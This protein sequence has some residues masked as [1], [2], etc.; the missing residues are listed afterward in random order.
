MRN[1]GLVARNAILTTM[2]T[3]SFWVMTFVVPLIFIVY[4]AFTALRDTGA[5]D[6][7]AEAENQASQPVGVSTAMP[8]MG[9]VDS[10]GSLAQLPA[11]FPDSFFNRYSDLEAAKLALDAGEIDQLVYIPP[12][13]LAS[14][15]VEIYTM[16]F[17]VT[18]SAA[19]SGLTFSGPNAWVLDYLLNYN[20]VG[21][22]ALSAALKNPTPGI[23]A[24]YHAL[25]PIQPVEP[26]DYALAN[27]VGMIVPFI[28]Y[29]VLVMSG[30]YLLQSVSKEKENRTAEVIL[31]S[32]SPRQFMVGKLLGLGV[33]S[34][35]QLL[36]WLGGSSLTLRQSASFLNLA[37]L[38]FSPSFY[39]WALL[40]LLGGYLMFGSIMAA[41]GALAP[42]AREGN[43]VIWLLIV[44][45]MPTLMFTSEFATDPNGALPLV[46]SLFP[47][48]APSAMVTRLAVA[49]VPAWQLGLSLAGVGLTAWVVVTL[50]GRFFRADHLLSDTAFTWTRLLKGWR[51]SS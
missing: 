14:G 25:Q 7:P 48:S 20:L 40:Y 10:Q 34:F 6:Q 8:V 51:K 28:F 32:V 13:Y 47:L 31:V 38:E 11:D 5:I 17:Q 2:R 49:P 42:T 26:G 39:L 15:R 35:I 19:E 43:Q 50:A 24:T 27:V 36:V 18:S 23:E 33:I 30:S 45:M 22:E 1:I 37:M 3:R 46:L 12:G 21:S 9:L 41:A 4:M 16:G 29:F 44:P